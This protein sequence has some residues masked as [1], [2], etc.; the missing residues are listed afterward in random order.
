MHKFL[1]LVSLALV[2]CTSPI[3]LEAFD[4]EVWKQGNEG[5]DENRRNM[6]TSLVEQKSLL[7][8]ESEARILRT[9]GQPDRNHL[10]GRNQKAYYYYLTPSSDCPVSGDSST[11]L[12]LRFNAVGI[13]SELLVMTEAN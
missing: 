2:S 3:Q 5:C 1:L 9:L 11:F 7:L 8:G 4:S 6:V 10:Y 13:A 12:N